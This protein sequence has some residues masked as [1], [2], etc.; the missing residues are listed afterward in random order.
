LTLH[1]IGRVLDRSVSYRVIISNFDAAFRVVA[2]NLGVSVIPIEVSGPFAAMR[3]IK[4]IPLADTCAQR[5]F[6]VCFEDFEA[7]QPAAQRMVDHLAKCAALAL[8]TCS[9]KA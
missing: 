3:S 8:A 1:A 2:A 7:L 5:N 9:E 6:A 4:V